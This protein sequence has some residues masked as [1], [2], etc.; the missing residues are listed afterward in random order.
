MKCDLLHIFNPFSR[1]YSGTT[2]CIHIR[3]LLCTYDHLHEFDV[4]MVT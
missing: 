2:R 1:F 3:S 4:Q